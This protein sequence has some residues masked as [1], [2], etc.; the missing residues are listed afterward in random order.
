ME[1][2]DFRGGINSD[3]SVL[4]QLAN[5]IRVAHESVQVAG[6]NALA[7]ALAVLQRP[8]LRAKETWRD[9]SIPS[10]WTEKVDRRI[11][12]H[13]KPAGLIG[14][15]IA[16]VTKTGDLVIDPAAGS[17]TVMHVAHELGRRFIG[18]DLCASDES[19][20]ATR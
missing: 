15:L 20:E 12:P 11:H 13:I 4:D 9:H 5:Q 3:I 18:C 17:F 6:A 1:H 7:H 16:A 10:R 19:E 14:R 2:N 8:P